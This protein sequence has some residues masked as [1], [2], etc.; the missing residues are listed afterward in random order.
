MGLSRI[1]LIISFIMIPLVPLLMLLLAST[2]T[3]QIPEGCIDCGLPD[4]PH[5]DFGDCTTTCGWCKIAPV[6][7]VKKNIQESQG[8]TEDCFTVE[9][10]SLKALELFSFCVLY[11]C[12][13]VFQTKVVNSFYLFLRN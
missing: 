12:F 6:M 2:C 1:V 7:D 11:S 9:I 4:H 8:W 5:C 10:S 13:S 3:A